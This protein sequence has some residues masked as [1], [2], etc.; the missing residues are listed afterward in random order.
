MTTSIK[1]AG[2]QITRNDVDAAIAECDRRGIDGF[3]AYYGFARSR[4]YWL[5]G[6][7]SHVPYPSKAI[8][9][10]AARA[11]K[12]HGYTGQFFGGA[13]HTV[14]QLRSL[15]YEVRSGNG[16][17]RDVD[18]D[19]IREEA[20]RHGVSPDLRNWGQLGATP[21]AYFASG[22]NRVGEIAG[23]ADVQHDIGVAAPEVRAK[24]EAEL[25]TLKGRESMLFVDSGAFTE[26]SFKTACESPRTPKGEHSYRKGES[27]CRYCDVRRDETDCFPARIVKPLHDADWQRVLGLY[28][29][30][31]DSLGGNLWAVAPDQVGSQAVT[32]ERLA[33]YRTEVQALAATGA[34][35]LV[36]AQK[37]E[38]SQ[39]AF[40]R[41]A[42]EVAGLGK[43]DGIN[44]APALPCKKAAT[45]ADE[46][47]AFVRELQPTHVHLLGL[48]VRNAKVAAYTAVFG[49][50][51]V[52]T[53]FSMD[54][55]WVTANV[56]RPD[57]GARPHTL[58][59][60]V[61][62]T[63]LAAAGTIA[64]ETSKTAQD[65]VTV[66]RAA[67][68]CTLGRPL[69]DEQR[70]R[71]GLI[72]TPRTPRKRARRS[73]R[74]VSSVDGMISLPWAAVA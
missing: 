11:T 22:S 62:R 46:V 44:V 31:A 12:R 63:I 14:R 1:V 30:L 45:A 17:A 10:V 7:R 21:V 35:V 49:A 50:D 68:R 61:C 34:K 3:C 73:S 8:L 72:E 70:E 43:W 38:L 67:L 57:S 26:V 47:A 15:N 13:A 40:Y 65:V 27:R 71:L 51:D 55:C 74:R 25:H 37:G 42:I 69:T 58:A 56:G 52:A 32:L 20:I 23:M 18:L 41:K 39:A 19:A 66:L 64:S 48:G 28:S 5:R 29:R 6:P 33:R 16:P 4:L 53:T 24:N 54:S 36:V 60:D 2:R 59:Q 9:A